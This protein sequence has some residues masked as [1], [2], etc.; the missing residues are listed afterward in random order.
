MGRPTS[1]LHGLPALRRSYRDARATPSTYWAVKLRVPGRRGRVKK[2]KRLLPAA[3][4]LAVGSGYGAV[5]TRATESARGGPRVELVGARLPSGGSPV[6]TSSPDL[7]ADGRF[8]V[9]VSAAADLVSGDT[10]A[11]VDVF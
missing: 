11:N 1:L 2:R 7:S 10:N 9:F 6:D 4:L 3:L 8:V 5:C